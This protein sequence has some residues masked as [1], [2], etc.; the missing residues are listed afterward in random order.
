MAWADTRAA[1]IAACGSCLQPHGYTFVKAR[2]GFEKAAGD[3]RGFYVGLVASRYGT[4]SMKPWC[5]VRN[6]AIE[7]V[8]HRTAGVDKKW[9]ATYTTI[10]TGVPAHWP[11][12]TA[13]EI[14][15][16]S[17]Q[18]TRYIV[19]T[20]LPFLEREYSYQ[21]YSDLLNADPTHWD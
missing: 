4:Y 6:A 11:L 15:V 1:V 13:D 18:A 17:E 19:E 3:R 21:D 16:A 12:D 9:Q 5:G 7:E 14:A 20:A 8:F 2:D 10:N